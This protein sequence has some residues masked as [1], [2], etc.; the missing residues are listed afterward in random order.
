[1]PYVFLALAICAVIL[2]VGLIDRLP[3]IDMIMTS[4]SL[5]GASER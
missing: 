4:V 3:V 1:M 5:A 2:V